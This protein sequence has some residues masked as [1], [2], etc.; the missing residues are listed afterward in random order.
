MRGLIKSYD[1]HSVSKDDGI[2][3]PQ[4]CRFLKLVYHL[5]SSFEKSLIE[6][7]IQ[8][9]HDKTESFDDYFTCKLREKLQTRS[10]RVLAK[11]IYKFP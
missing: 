3:C 4:T 7:T 8:Y 1:K 10:C 11:A 6:R 9:I 5:H 2:W